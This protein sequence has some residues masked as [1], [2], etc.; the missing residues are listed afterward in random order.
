MTVTKEQITETFAPIT[1]NIFG[2]IPPSEFGF[3]N[4]IIVAD[5]GDGGRQTVPVD[6]FYNMFKGATD[7][8]AEA[9]HAVDNG[10]MGY[11]EFIDYCDQTG[12]FEGNYQPPGTE[13]QIP[14]GPA[15]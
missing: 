2:F 11:S 9:F 12:L 8:T 15:E 6:T 5:Y 7:M 13:E 10:T 1:E 14:E 3:Y 4:A